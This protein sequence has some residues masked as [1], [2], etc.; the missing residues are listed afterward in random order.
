MGVAAFARA[1][2]WRLGV[3]QLVVALLAASTVVWFLEQCW[4]P[5]VRSAIEQLP[6]E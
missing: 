3:A 2:W 5:V 4:F 6:E 1:R